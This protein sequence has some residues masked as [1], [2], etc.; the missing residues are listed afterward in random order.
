MTPAHT[1]PVAIRLA[2]AVERTEGLAPG[3]PEAASAAALR[4]VFAS[5]CLFWGLDDDVTRLCR[6]GDPSDMLPTLERRRGKARRLAEL[7]LSEWG[8]L[9]AA[10]L[11]LD[12][13]PPPSALAAVPVS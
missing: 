4:L 5:V 1:L 3:T 8:H 2:Y 12:R 9:V 6:E 13:A 10:E 11:S 7:V